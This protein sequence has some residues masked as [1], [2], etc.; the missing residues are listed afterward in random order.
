MQTQIRFHRMWHSDQAFH[1]MLTGIL[2]QNE[3]ELENPQGPFQSFQYA[4]ILIL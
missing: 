2:I 1:C 4:N 3:T